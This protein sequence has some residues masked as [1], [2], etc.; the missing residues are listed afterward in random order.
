MISMSP[1]PTNLAQEPPLCVDLDHTLFLN[2]SLEDQ[3]IWMLFHHP[4]RLLGCVWRSGGHRAALKHELASHYPDDVVPGTYNQDLLELLRRQHAQGRR[5]VLVTA[6]N[7]RM[8]QRVAGDL[9]IFDA[10]LASTEAVNLKGRKKA[11]AL[12]AKFGTKS[13][14]YVGDAFADLPVWAAAR[15]GWLVGGNSRLL[16]A[17]RETVDLER[18]VPGSRPS[19]LALLSALRPHQWAKNLLVFV[20]LLAAH[21]WASPTAIVAAITT[22]VALCLTAS[23]VYLLNDLSDLPHDRRHLRKRH[24]AIASGAL[25]PLYAA[26]GAVVL[27][28]GGLILAARAGPPAVPWLILLYIGTTLFYSYRLKRVELLDVFTLASL[29]VLRIIVGG[30]AIGVALSSWLLAFSLFFFLSLALVKRF[31]EA[32]HAAEAGGR[33]LHGRGYQSGDVGFIA[34]LGSASGYIAV[35]ILALF[36]SSEEVSR[37][38]RQPQLLWFACVV[39]LYW[40]SRMWLLTHRRQMN[41]DPVLFAVKDRIS[42][43]CGGLVVLVVYVAATF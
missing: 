25:R 7:E 8:A 35:L 18:V 20:P 4:L 14:D 31:C 41:E 37:S 19:P 10:V 30:V 33:E 34:S 6:S 27:L 22:F 28:A 16:A 26:M 29:Y 2:D 15:K 43:L 24:R 11:D 13:F 42:Y 32:S 5:I 12:G 39:L 1:C 38:Y 21:L 17:A 3:A 23:G 40:I 36:L 9:G